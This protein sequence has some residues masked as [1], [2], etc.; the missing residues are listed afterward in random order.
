MYSGRSGFGDLAPSF[1]FTNTS[2]PG[3]ESV[4]RSGESWLVEITGPSNQPVWLVANG[5]NPINMGSTDTN[6][7]FAKTGAVGDGE[8]GNWGELWY[9]GPNFNT[10]TYVGSAQFAVVRAPDSTKKSVT[11]PPP[12]GGNN[13]PPPPPPPTPFDLGAAFGSIPPIVLWGGAG[14]AALFLLKG[15]R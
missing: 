3:S 13:A 1:K 14:L 15:K 11:D 5:L 10:G 2:R 12:G 9:V 4:F 8:I 7:R 6:G